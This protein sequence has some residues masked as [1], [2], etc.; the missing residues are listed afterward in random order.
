MMRAAL[1]FLVVLAAHAQA[2]DLIVE[3]AINPARVYAGGEALLMIRLLRAEG[4]SYGELKPPDLGDA[5]D[6]VSRHSSRSFRETRSGVSYFVLE[7]NFSVIPKRAGT[8]SFQGGSVTGLYRGLE[9]ALAHG[10]TLGPSLSLDVLPARAQPW[11]PAQRLTLEETWS[12]D[13]SALAAGAPVTL[14]LVLS[15]SG[16]TADRLPALEIPPNYA[17]RAHYDRPEV[18]TDFND[19]GLTARRVQRI[20]L[21]PVDDGEV[22]LPEIRVPWWDV[23]ADAP[24]VAVIPAR[25]IQV[26]ASVAEVKEVEEPIVGPSPL[27]RWVAVLMGLAAAVALWR[28]VRGHA[29]R[30]A[31]S[32]LREACRRN[33]ALARAMRCANGK[34]PPGS[35]RGST[36]S[37]STRRSTPA[38][39]STAWRSGRASRRGCAGRPW[40]DRRRAALFRLQPPA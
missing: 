13:P 10:S 38:A 18:V 25:T 28:Y 15:A 34:R 11:L 20:V 6:I 7:R 30:D 35:R 23:V 8:L 26:S 39:P 21:L 1:L 14:T 37:R 36:G 4:V 19:L 27:L 16:I 22:T 31:R 17:L 9:V 5:A 2:P 40:R 12:A 29:A 3:A 33:D 32:R 24:R